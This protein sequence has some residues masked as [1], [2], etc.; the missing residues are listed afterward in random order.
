MLDGFFFNSKKKPLIQDVITLSQNFMAES[1]CCV[2]E[3][4]EMAFL[5]RFKSILIRIGG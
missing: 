4:G 1:L 3:G 2:K 5:E